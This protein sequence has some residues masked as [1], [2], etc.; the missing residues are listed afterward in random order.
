[1]VADDGLLVV[2]V[3]TWADAVS[4]FNWF[5][6]AE[7]DEAAVP[8]GDD[9]AVSELLALTDWVSEFAESNSLITVEPSPRFSEM[10]EVA[11]A[12]GCEKE[13]VKLNEMLGRI[14][15]SISA[16][17]LRKEKAALLVWL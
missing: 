12:L 9:A 11:V 16:K 8:I 13:A 6:I 7:F 5:R 15:K 2:A 14:R 10:V 1:M 17:L 4:V 3:L